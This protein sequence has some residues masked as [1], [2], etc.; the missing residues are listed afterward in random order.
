MSDSDAPSPESAATEEALGLVPG[1]MKLLAC[2]A[3]HGDLWAGPMSLTCP[4][5][6]L[7]YPVED[8]I[9]VLLASR[10]ETL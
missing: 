2:P 1:S 3:C 4:N 7:R 10:A 6:R 8:G 9:P 5:C